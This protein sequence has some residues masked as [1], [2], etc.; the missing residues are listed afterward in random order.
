LL[1]RGSIGTGFHAPTV[2]QVN[3]SLR[4]YGVTS[5]KYTCT[6]ALLAMAK[7]L[8]AECQPGNKQYDQMA[9]GNPDLTPEKSKQATLGVRWEPNTSLSLGADL[10]HVQIADS[11]G[12]LTEQLVFADPANFAKSW[13]KKLDIAT[14]KTY[15]AFLADNKNLGNYYSTGL[16][17]DFSS[18]TKVA[19][20]LWT[21]Q[22]TL[23][24]MLREDQ[25]LVKDGPYYSA[26]GNFAEIG[27]VTFRDKGRLST[28]L[29]SGDW[30][31]TLAANFQSGYTDQTTTVDVLDKA[32]NVTGQ[33]DIRMEI[34]TYITLDWQTVWAPVG[35]PWSVTVGVQNLMDTPPPLSVSTGGLN[36]G[37]QFGYDDRYYDSRG[38]TV[39]LNA[40]YK[41]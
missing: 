17:L 1:V 40:S 37:Q 30:S 27:S 7:S 33:E 16:D 31:N 25:Q 28:T 41:F 18:R 8:G 23:T 20:G 6:P 3:A 26:I 38:R 35:K 9:A 21:T 34:G 5:D 19:M 12:Q 14:G 11:F 15:L 22:L 29:K 2:P 10:W 24:H 4:D 32:G 36:R 13:T 39:Y